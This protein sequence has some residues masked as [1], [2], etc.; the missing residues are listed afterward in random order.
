MMIIYGITIMVTPYDF[1]DWL[2]L[3]HSWKYPMVI[4]NGYNYHI[5]GNTLWLL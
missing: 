4:M 3:S 2:E 5:R 1:Y